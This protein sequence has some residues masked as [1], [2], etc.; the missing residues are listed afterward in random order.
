MQNSNAVVN[1]I[2][3]SMEMKQGLLLNKRCS[4]RR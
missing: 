3:L 2:Q 1:L 4:S